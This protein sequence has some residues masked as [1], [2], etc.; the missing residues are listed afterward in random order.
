M[1]TKTSWAVARIAK[2]GPAWLLGRE[3]AL[4]IPVS[5]LE[6]NIRNTASRQLQR[7]VLFSAKHMANL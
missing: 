4:S 6:E 7:A 2:S 1:G 3:Y 5:D